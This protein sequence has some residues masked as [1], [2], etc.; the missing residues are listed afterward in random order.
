M[1]TFFCSNCQ[2]PIVIIG[3]QWERGTANCSTSFCRVYRA[4]H[5]RPEDAE[6]DPDANGVLANAIKALEEREI[7]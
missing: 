7:L 5:H 3:T 2:Q 1:A 6:A 4:P